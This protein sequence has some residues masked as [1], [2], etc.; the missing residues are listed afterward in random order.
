MR[1]TERTLLPQAEST[2]TAL[3]GSWSAGEAT[4]AQVLLAE[5]AL[6][7]LRIDGDRARVAHARAWAALDA[8]CGVELPR[9]SAVEEP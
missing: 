6:L 1:V 2:Y 3:L 5:Q 9:R 7:E 8:L 4:V